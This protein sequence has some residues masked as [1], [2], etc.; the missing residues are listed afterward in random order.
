MQKDFSLLIYQ[1]LK[2]KFNFTEFRKG[3]YEAIHTLMTKDRLLCIQPTGYGK[4]LLYQLPALLLDG[5]TLVI[6]PLLALVRD[7]LKQL[8]E[9]FGIAATS[10]NSDQSM[11]ENNAAREQLLQGKIKILFISPEQLDNLTKFNFLLNLPIQLLVVD[12]AHC[13]STWGHDFRPSYRYIIKLIEAL[14][15]KNQDLKILALTATANKKTEADIKTQLSIDKRKITVHRESMHRPNIRLTVLH[16]RSAPTKLATVIALLKKENN[17]RLLEGNGLIYCATRENT[18][19]VAEYLLSQGINTAAYHAGM[20]TARKKQIQQNFLSNEYHVIV[21]TN[22]L[23]MGIDKSNLRF[24]IHFDVPGSITAYYQEVGRCGRDGLPADGVLL[25]DQKDVRIQKHF[26]ESSQPRAEDFQKVNE[27]IKKSA[28]SINLAGLKQLTGMHP[29]KLN[30]ALTELIE[31]GY[32]KKVLRYQ[33]QFYQVVPKAGKLNL[34]RYLT[35]YKSKYAELFAM[36]NYAEQTEKC[37][38]SLLQIALGDKSAKACH[39]CS[40]CTESPFLF[41]KDINCIDET[42]D[43]FEERAVRSRQNKKLNLNNLKTYSREV[44]TT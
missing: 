16:T 11:Q 12:E 20:E 9:R 5:I 1:I 22:A 38:M 17:K 13:I 37:A 33:S 7:Q 40:H 43:W 6:S 41:S 27:V 14:V 44:I 21:A 15:N 25:Y 29:N 42:N 4:S 2:T 19:I 3:Q 32:V 34:K 36:Q 10:F 8:H 30:V 35:Q 24:I 39:Q 23:G 26:I 31:Q 18:E 28:D